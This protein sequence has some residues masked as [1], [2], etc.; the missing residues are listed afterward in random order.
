MDGQA[1]RLAAAMVAA[2]AMAWA[3]CAQAGAAVAAFSAAPAAV[4]GDAGL[5]TRW[6][7][8]AGDHRGRPFAVVDKKQARLY[9]FDAR[10]R[11]AGATPALLGATPGDHIVPG[12]G[13]RAQ[14]GAVRADERTTPAGRFEAEPGVNHTGE[15]VVWADYESA[16][17]I[18]RLRPGNSHAARAARLATPAA[19]D[20][21]VSLGCVVVPVAFYRDVVERVL[22]N[23]RSVV[24]VLPETRRVHDVFGRLQAAAH[25]RMA[26]ARLLPTPFDA[27]N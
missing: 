12:V 2:V 6:V 3:G 9:V 18:H 21:R 27:V 26:Q 4:P 7:L 17:A 8:D 16:F 25:A 15:H 24:Y 23:G 5:V 22:G 19:G 1:R 10:G 20:K 11:L 14:R 13:E